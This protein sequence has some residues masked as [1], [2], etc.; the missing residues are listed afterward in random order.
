[1][2]EGTVRVKVIKATWC[3]DVIKRNW[4]ERLLSSPWKPHIKYKLNRNAY[5]DR[6]KN[7]YYV[8]PEIFKRLSGKTQGE[9]V[10]FVTHSALKTMC[11]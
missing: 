6:P 9:N 10:K 2:S 3:P 7:I 5:F 11:G 1:M 8:C 4:K